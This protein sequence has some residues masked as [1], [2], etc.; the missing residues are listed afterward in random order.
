MS[1]SRLYNVNGL[2]LRTFSHMPQS[3]SGHLSLGL[4]FHD[5]PGW[6]AP[7][8]LIHIS[9]RKVAPQA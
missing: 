4:V 9:R 7:I 2:V 6:G 8:V 1:I 5:C 3:W